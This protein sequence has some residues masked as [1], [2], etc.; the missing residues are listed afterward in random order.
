MLLRSI[1][2]ATTSA[3]LQLDGHPG[4]RPGGGVERFF[5]EGTG[6]AGAGP[7][8]ASSSSETAVQSFSAHSQTVAQDQ[9]AAASAS[10]AAASRARLRAILARQ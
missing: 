10:I 1:G 7:R 5:D 2:T 9:P 3:L 4:G 6:D 8:N